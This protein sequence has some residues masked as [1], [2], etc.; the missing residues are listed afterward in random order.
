MV[1]NGARNAVS[2][3]AIRVAK[4]RR[5]VSGRIGR[6]SVWIFHKSCV[7]VHHFPSAA[8]PDHNHGEKYVLELRHS[9]LK[10]LRCRSI[11][12]R[13]LHTGGNSSISNP[14]SVLRISHLQICRGGRGLPRAP[15]LYLTYRHISFAPVSG[16]C[17]L[18]HTFRG[19]RYSSY[20]PYMPKKPTRHF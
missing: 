12:R 10:Y 9:G 1:V 13:N 19:P 18:Y 17:K 11:E 20:G 7:P 4:D 14:Y 3:A 6:N 16:V 8:R 15:Y 5:P 2:R